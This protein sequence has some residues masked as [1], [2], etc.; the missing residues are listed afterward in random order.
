MPANTTIYA[1]VK[2]ML[3]CLT[4]S[5]LMVGCGPSRKPLMVEVKQDGNVVASGM[6]EIDGSLKGDALWTA[7]IQAE[8]TGN[9]NLKAGDKQTRVVLKGD[10]KVTILS[11]STVLVEGSTK[12]LTLEREDSVTD[13]W[14]F[15]DSDLKALAQSSS[16]E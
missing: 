1:Y 4:L 7:A 10:I 11:G 16:S 12:E 5:I 6:M 14:F 8:V 15:K 3:I 9:N 13:T 2:L